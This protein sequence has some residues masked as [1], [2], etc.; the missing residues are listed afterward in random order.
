MNTKHSQRLG[1]GSLVA[2]ILLCIAW[3]LN[4]SGLLSG[5]LLF[6]QLFGYINAFPGISSV[7]VGS[8][9]PGICFINE[10]FTGLESA[11]NHLHGGKQAVIQEIISQLKFF[12]KGKRISILFELSPSLLK[13]RESRIVSCECA[14]TYWTMPSVLVRSEV[15]SGLLLCRLTGIML[16]P[17][18][19]GM[20]AMEKSHVF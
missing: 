4:I 8:D 3:F 9:L 18:G 6:Q 13:L 1:P 10:H 14:F 5:L 12:A 11:V 19:A 16:K 7:A 2:F 17:V 20:M 15:L